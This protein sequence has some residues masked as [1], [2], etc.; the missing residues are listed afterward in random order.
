MW[1]YDFRTN[2]H[3]TLKQR[4]LHT[5]HLDDFVAAYRPGDPRVRREPSA[6]F[7]PYGIDELLARDKANLDLYADIKDE[8][9]GN[10]DALLDP[11]VVAEE[12]VEE[13]EAAL[14]EFAAVAAALRPPPSDADTGEDVV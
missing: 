4:P 13:L 7:K 5:E 9:L 2:Q 3:F 12:I 14:S 11:Y 10:G 6:A 1:V 8:A